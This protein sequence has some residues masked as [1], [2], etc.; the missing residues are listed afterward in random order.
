MK[1]QFAICSLMTSSNSFISYHM[2]GTR[3]I[4]VV[5]LHWRH[6]HGCWPVF[7]LTRLQSIP[8]T[9]QLDRKSCISTPHM[10][11]QIVR[12][13]VSVLLADPALNSIFV[14]IT[15]R[16]VIARWSFTFGCFR[17][18]GHLVSCCL[19]GLRTLRVIHYYYYYYYWGVRMG[20]GEGSTMRNFIVSTV[21]LIY[22]GWLNLE[23]W[24][25][26]GM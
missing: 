11:L 20:R 26:Q 23:D 14:Q 1:E 12:I 17:R 19:L 13:I 24:D 5:L 8:S 2:L 3:P 21:H 15:W 9:S 6:P 18:S 4:W 16:S 22:S 10:S 7:P 25:G